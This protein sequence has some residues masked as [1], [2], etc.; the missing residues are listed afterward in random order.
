MESRTELVLFS[1]VSLGWREPFP[2]S[3]QTHQRPAWRLRGGIKCRVGCSWYCCYNRPSCVTITLAWC[4]L[5]INQS[6]IELF[7]KPG[8][9]MSTLHFIFQPWLNYSFT[10]SYAQ[11]TE[12]LCNISLSSA[13]ESPVPR[14]S[15]D[16]FQLCLNFC[17]CLFDAFPL[18]RSSPGEMETTPFS[19]TA[20][21][22]LSLMAMRST[23]VFVAPSLKL[24]IWYTLPLTMD[25]PTWIDIRRRFPKLFLIFSYFLEVPVGGRQPLLVPQLPHERPPRRLWGARALNLDPTSCPHFIHRWKTFPVS[26]DLDSW[27]G[28]I[29][30]FVSGLKVVMWRWSSSRSLGTCWPSSDSIETNILDWSIGNK[31]INKLYEIKHRG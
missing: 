10:F 25:L 7:R 30:L 17:Y 11:S 13:K 23:K 12:Q 22:T 9:C 20:M 15:R 3:Q 19:T 24:Y 18:C 14:F 8:S 28:M 2:D 29:F 5:H 16:H 21:S 27:Q 26:I 31:V 1:E 6:I 4:V